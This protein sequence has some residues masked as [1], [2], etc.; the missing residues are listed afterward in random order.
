MDSP[1]QDMDAEGVGA[2]DCLQCRGILCGVTLL[3][4]ICIQCAYDVDMI[5][6]RVPNISKEIESLK[7]QI[8]IISNQLRK[9]GITPNQVQLIHSLVL[10]QTELAYQ[11]QSLTRESTQDDVTVR[12]T[13]WM[14]NEFFPPESK[15]KK[16]KSIRKTA[17]R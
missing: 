6:S 12:I 2:S 16:K 5:K 9:T 1:V 14:D 13:E 4:A 15:K 8:H 7:R 3:A 11:S 17:I 10:A